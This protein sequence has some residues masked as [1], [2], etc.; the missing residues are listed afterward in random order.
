MDTL[1]D[2]HL[3]L[4][5]LRQACWVVLSKSSMIC[6][7]CLLWSL[8]MGFLGLPIHARLSQVDTQPQSLQV[9]TGPRS[10]APTNQVI[11]AIQVSEPSK[12]N[13]SIAFICLGT[14]LSVLGSLQALSIKSNA[15]FPASFPGVAWA[16]GGMEMQKHY[17]ECMWKNPRKHQALGRRSCPFGS[18]SIPFDIMAPGQCVK[19]ESRIYFT[20]CV[21]ATH[22]LK[23]S[24]QHSFDSKS[25]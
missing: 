4:S 21:K 9:I 24:G 13:C 8:I 18:I 1:P 7:I 15:L 6:L 22:P 2:T 25:R 19:I 12:A 23:T 17:W 14:F 3:R 5:A 11:Q 20:W 16:I 10:Q